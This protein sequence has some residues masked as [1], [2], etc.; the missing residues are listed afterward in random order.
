MT[1]IE[2]IALPFETDIGFGSRARIG[3]I[4]LETD[5]TIE[6]EFR[7]LDIANV[8]WYHAR[9]PM[10]PEVTPETLTDMEERLPVAAALLPNEFEF[11]AIGYG[12]TSAATLIGEDGVRN[13]IQSAH[14][15]MAV[16]NPISAAVSAFDTLGA[17]RIAVVTPYTADVTA[18]IVEH[19]TDAGLQ[20]TSVGSFLE[21]RDHV[22][23]KISEASVAAAV[24]QI[25]AQG[26]CDGVFIS[27][28]SLRAFG[29]IDGL[30]QELGVPVVSS[31]LA[32]S[33]KLLRM[34]GITE[35]IPNRGRL[36]QV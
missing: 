18:P 26:D 20:V 30:E 33:W 6:A 22:V 14:P 12:C 8:A 2:P 35:A 10:D 31:N 9:I 24:R 17:S 16:S 29:I 36:F 7:S 34:A 15:G 4:V 5:H 23:A 28:T 32:L 21:S 11:D 1:L 19:F 27:C 13:A 3:L 25:A